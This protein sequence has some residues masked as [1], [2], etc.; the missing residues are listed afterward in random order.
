MPLDVEYVGG[1][2]YPIFANTDVKLEQFF[3][4]PHQAIVVPTVE[5]NIPKL[6]SVTS[7]DRPHFIWKANPAQRHLALVGGQGGKDAAAPGGKEC[8]TFCS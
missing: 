8:T 6:F 4:R 2:G 1:G 5:Y 3:A 7:K